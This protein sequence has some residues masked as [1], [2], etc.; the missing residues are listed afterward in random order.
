MNHPLATLFEQFLRERTYL[1]NV[2]PPTLIWYRVAFKNYRAAFPD[3]SAPTKAT[4]QQFVIGLRERNLRP[5]TCNTYIGAMNAFCR[6]LHEE[7]HAKDRVRLQKLRLEWRV[8]DLLNET[9]MRVLIG[10]KPKTYRETRLH[11][12][13]LLVLDTGLRISEALGLRD[14]DIDVDNLILK[15]LGKGQKGAAGAVLPRAAEAPLSALPA[16]LEQGHPQHVR[17]C[18]L[19]RG[20]LGEAQCH[21]F[22][23][24]APAEAGPAHVRLRHT[25][26]TNYLRHGGDIVRL[27]MVLGHTQITT[28][29]RYLHLLTED[30]SASHQRV[31]ILN[32]LG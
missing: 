2:T 30:L 28:T 29:Q 11:V 10:Y 12:A 16:A 8:L 7:G 1:K 32:R 19:R 5:V 14:S 17:V 13:V 6:W 22:A 31:S 23:P 26:A 25:F 18:R 15:A 20:P 21:A 4:M 3:E 27:S 9:Q 24:P